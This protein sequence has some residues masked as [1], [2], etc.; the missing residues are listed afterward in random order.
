[1]RVKKAQEES[2]FKMTME[3]TVLP[4]ALLNTRYQTFG[5]ETTTSSGVEI[6]DKRLWM[7]LFL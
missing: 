2:I 3:P 7:T 6:K 1:M 5:K 4:T